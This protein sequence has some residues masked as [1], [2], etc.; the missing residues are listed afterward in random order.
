MSTGVRPRRRAPTSPPLDH[1]H[2]DEDG[3]STG[4]LSRRHSAVRLVNEEH[5]EEEAFHDLHDHTSAP[6]QFSGPFN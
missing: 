1:D 3:R 5:D 2:M 6:P 4:K